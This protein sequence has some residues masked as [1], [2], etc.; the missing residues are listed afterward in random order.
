M[1]VGRKKPNFTI[2]RK[3]GA[4]AL[5]LH[6]HRNSAQMLCGNARW[7]RPHHGCG[8]E[9]EEAA[10]VTEVQGSSTADP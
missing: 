3:L 8:L 1:V 7:D 10:E 4:A 5:G 6:R 9:G 2:R